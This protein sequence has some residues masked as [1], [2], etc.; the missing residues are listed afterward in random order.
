ME[1]LSAS[2]LKQLLMASIGINNMNP[3]VGFES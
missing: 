2:I 1:A 3:E